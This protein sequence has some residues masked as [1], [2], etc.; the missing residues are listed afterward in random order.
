MCI[1]SRDRHWRGP[2]VVHFV[3]VFVDGSVVQE[4]VPV[5]KDEVMAENRH[6]NVEE[7]GL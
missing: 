6:Q 1:Q 7:G 4:P 2:L 3:N 5:I